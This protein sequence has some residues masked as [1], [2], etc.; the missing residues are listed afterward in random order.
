[1]IVC[2]D[3]VST[4]EGVT[5][6]T[7]RV[8]NLEVGLLRWRRFFERTGPDGLSAE[9][10][11]GLFAELVCLQRLLK[12]GVDPLKVVT[13][14]KG[15]ERRD[16]DFDLGGHV[17]EV[18]ST[19][20]KEPKSVAISSERQLD[21]RDLQSL[22]LYVLTVHEVENGGLTLPEQVESVRQSLINEPVV[23]ADFQDRLVSTGYLDRDAGNY[24]RHLIVKAEDLYR[25]G[26]GFPRITSV[27]SGVGDMHYCVIL[28]VCE[29]YRANLDNHLMR[30]VE[31]AN[32]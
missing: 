6:A 30:L 10:Q 17:I 31:I 1:M 14:W 32:G 24:T 22:H 26:E 13:A 8:W 25:V 21:D 18:K 16:Y 15:C 28:A 27:P 2:E 20:G 19:R 23:L 4:L 12:A 9:M 11:Q 7:Q 5:E 3:L 29:P